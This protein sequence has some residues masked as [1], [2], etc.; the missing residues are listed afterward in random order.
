MKTKKNINNVKKISVDCLP[1]PFFPKSANL[2]FEETLNSTSAKR[3]DS[4]GQAK[5]A[6]DILTNFSLLK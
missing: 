3:E 1:H 2:A 5:E 6:L 4:P